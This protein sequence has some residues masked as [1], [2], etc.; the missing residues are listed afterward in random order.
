MLFQDFAP[1]PAPAEVAAAFDM[2]LAAFLDRQG[3]THKDMEWQVC[4]CVMVC[5]GGGATHQGMECQVHAR[6]RVCV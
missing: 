4:V 2:P 6:A 1:L 3:H 5:V